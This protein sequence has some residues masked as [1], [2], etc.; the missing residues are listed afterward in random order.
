MHPSAQI[1]YNIRED[2]WVCNNIFISLWKLTGE[3][4]RVVETD[5]DSTVHGANMGPTWVL[6]APAWPHLGPISLAFRGYADFAYSRKMTARTMSGSG[7]NRMMIITMIITI[8][9]I[10]IYL[11]RIPVS[12]FLFH[13]KYIWSQSSGNECLNT[14]RKKLICMCSLKL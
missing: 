10:Y 8:I 14:V 13:D 3:Y 4:S 5:P 6:S 9:C 12:C 1:R 2:L 11:G 7:R